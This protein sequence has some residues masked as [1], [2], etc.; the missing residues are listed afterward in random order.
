MEREFEVVGTQPVRV[1]GKYIEP[2][3][4]FNALPEEVAFYL[5]IG[6][7]QPTTEA[8]V[9]PSDPEVVRRKMTANAKENRGGVDSVAASQSLIPGRTRRAVEE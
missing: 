1:R 4:T 2:G 8:A 3:G 7:V 9:E 6:A 5:Q